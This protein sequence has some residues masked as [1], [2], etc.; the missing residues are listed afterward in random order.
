MKTHYITR[1]L[2]PIL[3]IGCAMGI[4]CHYL[5]AGIM[6]SIAWRAAHPAIFYALPLLGVLTIWVYQR[7]GQG[8]ERGNNLIIDSVEKEAV[9][10]PQMGLLTFIF[11]ILSHLFGASVGREGSAVQIGGAL[12][13]IGLRYLP[14]S[15]PYRRQMVL[16]GVSAGFSAMFG[17][18]LAGA[19]FGMEMMRVGRFEREGLIGC[20][21][22]AYSAYYTGHW[23]K[24]TH[25]VYPVASFPNLTAKV[26]LVVCLAGVAFGL[27]ARLFAYLVKQFKAFYQRHISHPL[28]RAGLAAA[29]VVAVISIIPQGHQYQSLSLDMLHHAFTE[30]SRWVDPLFKC[31]TTTLSLG[32]GFQGGEVTPLFGIG[33]TLGNVIGQITHLEPSFLA[34]LGMIGVFGA[35]TNAPLTMIMLGIDLFGVQGAVYYVLIA[36]ICYYSSGHGGIY[37]AQVIE[38]PKY[39]DN[40]HLIGKQLS[41]L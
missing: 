24:T 3:L 23:M 4:I 26:F 11:T 1:F 12:S 39:L 6:S 2:L 25:S 21:L 32:A 13:H 7:F 22:G 37:G 9:V 15:A 8:A 29:V 5:I 38:R 31:L 16:A 20:F 17:T 18:P 33:A 35:A 34:G 14:L 10:P 30:H 36:L 27:M 40:D 41:D 28:L 19:F